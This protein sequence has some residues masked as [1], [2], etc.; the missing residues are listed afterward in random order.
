MNTLYRQGDVL[1]RRVAA[2]PDGA[3]PQPRDDRGRIVIE[4][5]EHTGHA[6]CVLV[7]DATLYHVVEDAGR[8]VAQYLAVTGTGV[9][10]V[11]EEHNTIALPPGVYQRWYQQEY[12][13]EEERRVID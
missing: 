4:R 2:L 1:F 8:V 13:G 6:H 9:D 7:Q 12:A 5:G 3:M 10:L 11:H